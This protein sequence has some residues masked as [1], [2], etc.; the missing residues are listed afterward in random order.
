MRNSSFLLVLVLS[1]LHITSQASSA[2]RF[3]LHRGSSLSVDNPDDVLISNSGVFSA[4]FY[5]VGENAYCFAVWFSRPPC[6]GQN[7]TIVWMANRDKPVNGRHSKLS[8]KKNGNLVLTDAGQAIVWAQNTVS[9]SSSPVHQLQLLDSGNLVLR[10][11][12]NRV[13]VWQ[14]FDSPTDT[15]LPEQNLTRDTPLVSSRSKRNFS[16]GY[17]KLY[18]DNDNVLRLLFDG[19]SFSSVYWPDPSK[20]SWEVGRTTYNDSR[21]AMLDSFGNF[22][23][24]DDLKFLSSDFGMKTE[25][26]LKVD[27]DGNV[28]V[29]SRG[30]GG[31]WVVTWQAITEPCT[32]H[33]ICGPNGVCS[34]SPSE[35]RSC[36]C[37]PGYVW[38]HKTDWI[39]GCVPKFKSFCNKNSETQVGFLVLPHHD[40][41]GYDID[42]FPNVT[43]VACKEM[44]VNLCNCRG[45][46]YKFNK[47]TGSFDCYIKI[48]LLNGCLSLQQ[49]GSMYIKLPKANLSSYQI[50]MK[51]FNTLPCPPKDQEVILP[52]TY[53]K[54]HRNLVL[55]ILLICAMVLAVVEAVVVFLTWSFLIGAGRHKGGAYVNGYH[56]AVTGC[57]RFTYA[58]LKKATKNF[59]E[60]IGRGSRGI[61]YRGLLQ[62]HRVAAVKRLYG[63]NQGEEAFLAEVTTIGN[64]NHKNL[65][66]MWGYC[67]E[68]KHR[69]L[70]YEFM[71]HGSLSENLSSPQLDWTKRNPSGGHAIYG[72]V[73]GGYKRSTSWVR[74][75][76]KPGVAMETWIT[77]YLDPAIRGNL[78]IKKIK[79]LVS[80][81]LQCVEE[82][83]DARPT[84][85]QV[86]EMLLRHE[87]GAV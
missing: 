1:L 40:F 15:L 86:V 52:R 11:R 34:Y 68:G 17:Y 76:M 61:V 31:E 22:T 45:F 71:D 21:V 27:H 38:K 47:D 14:S 69:L 48:R 75:K 41:Y 8:L 62:D 60:E 85:S 13:T 36:S 10:D 16:S 28:R 29:Y 79:V 33:G 24:S 44:C 81:A 56:P 25:R 64:L 19:P 3:A 55:E 80:V 12:E 46:Q 30:G 70:V 82:D 9:L 18:F 78:D 87:N 83:R 37:A 54:S 66:E 72:E 49:I 57:R 6:S 63:V 84:M 39:Q 59:R 53:L 26:I 58:E 42:Y 32:V 35:G 7:C 77:E 65:I 5:P 74:E 2:N 73:K 43:L 51:E 67:T 4:G 20:V 50:P 23:S